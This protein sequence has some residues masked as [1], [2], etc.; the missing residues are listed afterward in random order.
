M[1]KDYGDGIY[2][3]GLYGG[4]DGVPY[5]LAPGVIVE[6]YSNTKTYK[7]AFQSGV[8]D[9][10]GCDFII[11]ESGPESFTLYFAKSVEIL[12]RD[13]IKI[14]L[15]GSEDY[16]FSGVVRTVPIDGSTKQEYNYAGFGL[17]DYI[18]RINTESLSYANKTIAYILE[19]ILDDHITAKSPIEKVAS[20]IDPPNITIVSFEGNYSS[21]SDVIDALLK[22]ANSAGDYVCGVDQNNAFFFRPRSTEI[23]VTLAVGKKGI[24]GI[25]NYEPED[26]YEA[27]SKFFVLDKDGIFVTT[28]TTDEDNDIMEEKITAPDI[29]NASI[30]AWA[31]GILAEKEINTRSASIMWPIEKIDP[32][33]LL[34]DGYIRIISNVPPTNTAPLNPNP[35]GSG[36]FGSGIFG[37]GQYTG[38]DIDDTLKIVEV[39]YTINS[40]EATRSIQLGSLPPRIEDKVIEIRKNLSDLRVSLGR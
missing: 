24:Y 33:L 9:F 39:S 27:A 28:I 19:D 25:D 11:S 31:N 34:A 30:I 13:I 2:G 35:F 26:S 32:M 8:G 6:W 38:K 5:P 21:A 17:Y 10:L 18:T 37:G 4:L 40:S 12:K 7:G 20:N 29:D 1:P 14:R 23:K 22:I 16:F 15:F 3:S 36:P